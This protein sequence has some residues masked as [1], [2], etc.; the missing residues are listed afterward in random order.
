VKVLN[1]LLQFYLL[2]GKEAKRMI[3][4]LQVAKKIKAKGLL[5][6]KL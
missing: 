3:T 4:S 6:A 2:T 1:K 5:S